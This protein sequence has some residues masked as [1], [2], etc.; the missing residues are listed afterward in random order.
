MAFHNAIPQIHQIHPCEVLVG[1]LL[2]VLLVEKLE[3]KRFFSSWFLGVGPSLSLIRSDG[4]S[5]SGLL[6]SGGSAG[7]FGSAWTSYPWRIGVR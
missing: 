1:V 3:W 6:V 2:T 4:N 7:F 5:L